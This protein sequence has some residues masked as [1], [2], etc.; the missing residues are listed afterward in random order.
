M[1]RAGHES[2]IKASQQRHRR[3]ANFSSQGQIG[4]REVN[5]EEIDDELAMRL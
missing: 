5:V 4:V 3:C 1:A 2:F